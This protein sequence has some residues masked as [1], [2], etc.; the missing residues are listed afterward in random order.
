VLLV[1]VLLAVPVLLVVMSQA[2]V[3]PD[4]RP[5]VPRTTITVPA[6]GASDPSS[7]TAAPDPPTATGLP[8]AAPAPSPPATG[9][10][11]L[12]PADHPTGVARPDPTVVREPV[13]SR[14][15]PDGA[16]GATGATGEDGEDA[17]DL[18]GDDDEADD[19]AG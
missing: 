3:R 6:V 1:A 5:P 10:A 12:S 2:L 13:P 11:P 17:D 15:A 18:G 16:T 14:V 4:D 8:T 9:G 19:G 7:G